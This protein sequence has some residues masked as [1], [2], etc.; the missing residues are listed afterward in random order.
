MDSW[1]DQASDEAKGPSPTGFLT[2]SATP[3]PPKVG[4]PIHVARI[5]PIPFTQVMA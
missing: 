5:L 3:V 1:R 2:P 4:F